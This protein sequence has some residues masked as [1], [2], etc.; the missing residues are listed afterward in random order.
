MAENEKQ[1]AVKAKADVKVDEKLEK[2]EPAIAADPA[3]A[4]LPV[5]GREDG[6]DDGK[7]IDAANA[8]RETTAELI[9]ADGELAKHNMGIDES[10]RVEPSNIDSTDEQQVA[11]DKE[12]RRFSRDKE[13]AKAKPDADRK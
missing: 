12:D 4:G 2:L 11:Q 8:P 10:Q 3:R 6:F 7:N 13:V 5:V 9:V 1:E